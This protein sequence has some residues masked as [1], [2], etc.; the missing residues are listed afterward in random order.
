MLLGVVFYIASVGFRRAEIRGSYDVLRPA[1]ELA[2]HVYAERPQD[3]DWYDILDPN[4]DVSITV[5]DKDGTYLQIVGNIKLQPVV[6]RGLAVFHGIEAAYVGRTDSEGRMYVVAEPFVT[7]RRAISRFNRWLIGF[8][9]PLIFAA[10]FVTWLASRSTFLPLAQLAEQA[11][12]LS[13]TDLSRRLEISTKDEY[14]EVARHLN[15]F[16]SLLESSVQ[17]QRR[18]VADA[19]HELRTPLTVIRGKIETTLLRSR[20]AEDY[21]AALEISLSEAER[22]SRL[23]DGLLLSASAPVVKPQP[24]D[25]GSAMEAAEARWLDRF[26]QAGM[27]LQLDESCS[28]TVAIRPEEFD[29]VV[30]NLLSNALKYADTKTTT[31]LGLHLLADGVEVSVR[32]E[33]PGVLPEFQEHIFE[34]F[35]RGEA[36]RNRD[37]GGFGIG[38]SVVKRIVES[39]GGHV[40]L[41]PS[42]K[43]A[44]F[45]VYLP[46]AQE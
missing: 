45:V 3:P 40:R 18:F 9:F 20:S 46:L 2:I 34:R 15:T 39:R 30:D 33:G 21:R 4:P 19:A 22:L 27:E 43:G 7:K 41:E 8:Y 10:G 28:A 29:S 12:K 42:D 14:A 38:L 5:F 36:S 31:H 16:L 25:V 17:L 37:L 23:V 32:D 6:G 44:H 13:T 35:A 11:E 24:I 26:S 1:D